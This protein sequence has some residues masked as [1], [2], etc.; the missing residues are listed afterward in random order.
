MSGLAENL[1]YALAALASVGTGIAGWFG[2][3]RY[4]GASLD[5]GIAEHTATRA[6]ADANSAVYTRMIERLTAAEDG[7]RTLRH[8][9][10][11]VR[12]QLR[13]SEDHI[14]T[15]ERTMRSHGVVPPPYEALRMMEQ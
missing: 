3:R 13:H 14:A 8:E 7:I 6:V 9:V 5:A 12:R 15:L 1:G 11:A 10:D 4:F 2:A